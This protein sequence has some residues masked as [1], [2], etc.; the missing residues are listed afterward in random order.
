MFNLFCS[1]PSYHMAIQ[2]IC[3]INQIN[4]FILSLMHS[5]NVLYLENLL[6][7]I[8]LYFRCVKMFNEVTPVL[9]QLKEPSILKLDKICRQANV[10]LV[11]ARS[12]GLAGL[13]RISLKVV[14]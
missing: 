7:S 11:V 2:L 10:M 5:I 13:V 12:Y 6:N 9:Y 4:F 3:Y 1:S 8:Y 14:F